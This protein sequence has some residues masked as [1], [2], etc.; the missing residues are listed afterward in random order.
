MRFYQIFRKSKA[1]TLAETLITLGII[2]I[3]AAIT[4]PTIMHK[5]YEHQTVARLKE[6]YSI[7]AQ[8]LKSLDDDYGSLDTWGVTGYNEDS[9]K[10]IAE[11]L[12][13]VIKIANDCGTNDETGSCIST[14]NYRFLNNKQTISYA[15]DTHYYK[16]SLMNGSS[17]IIKGNDVPAGKTDVKTAS[18]M[19]DTN[20]KDKP[21]MWGK[22]FF[23]IDY[24]PDSGLILDG[25]PN[26]GV[27]DYRGKGNCKKGGT[28]WGCAYYV[29][30]F[31]K[32]D[33]L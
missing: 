17:I 1:F 7:L 33:Y 10:V 4:I 28:G 15:K 14:E 18:F 2:G 27:S 21:N 25:N 26:K 9:A 12:K 13:T 19:I 8:A 32:M 30:T 11:K 16:L 23:E 29:V 22:D 5:Y 24:I 20:G 31:G 6:T 3:V